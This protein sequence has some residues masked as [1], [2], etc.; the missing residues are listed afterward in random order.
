MKS[1]I[2]KYF[3]A[4]FLTATFTQFVLA[5]N[6]TQTL[7]KDS[8]YQ[9]Q[10][11]TETTETGITNQDIHTTQKKEFYIDT[12]GEAKTINY[13]VKTAVPQ[14]YGIQIKDSAKYAKKTLAPT[15]V[16]AGSFIGNMSGAQAITRINNDFINNT[17]NVKVGISGGGLIGTVNN[18]EG[19][20]RVENIT[21]D[22]I[23]NIVNAQ[24]LSGSGLIGNYGYGYSNSSD[25]IINNNTQTDVIK[26]NFIGNKIT[27]STY[28]NGSGLIGNFAHASKN[29]NVTTKIG[30]I[31]GNFYNNEITYTPTNSN[32]YNMFGG[33][34][35]GNY[36]FTYQGNAVANANIG[37]ISG[38]FVNNK[39]TSNTSIYGGGLIGNYTNTNSSGGTANASIDNIKGN[40]IK[41]TVKADK[42]IF[43]GIIG[44]YG[45]TSKNRVAL[46]KEINANFYNNH[47]E[48]TNATNT[49]SRIQGGVI[50]NIGIS[51]T[52]NKITG[53][54]I[55]N[56]AIVNSTNNTSYAYG[57]AIYNSGNITEGI[58]NS[59]FIG[60]YVKGPDAKG[61]AIYS[62]KDITIMANKYNSIFSGNYTQNATEKEDNAI[63]IAGNSATLTLETK[64][65]GTIIMK[66]SINGVEGYNVHIKSDG[67]GTF[68]MYNDIKNANV[69]F[70]NTKIS[71]VNHQIHDYTFNS[72]MLS[73]TTKLYVDVD[74][75]SK[76]MDRVIA[77]TYGGNGKLNIAGMNL[78]SD[79]KDTSETIKF[80]DS[81]LANNVTSSVSTAYS[82]IYKYTVSYVIEEDG[83][84]YFKFERGAGKPSTS[85]PGSTTIV[86]IP[87]TISKIKTEFYTNNKGK[88]TFINYDVKSAD[89]AYYTEKVNN[90]E[91]TEGYSDKTLQPTSVYGYG[92]TGNKLYSS[93]ADTN[94]TNV[95]GN[96]VG[97]KVTTKSNV[98]GSGLIGNYVYNPEKETK[99]AVIQKISGNFVS[100][101][102]T[103]NNVYGA[104]LVGNYSSISTDC[105]AGTEIKDIKGNFIGNTIT[106]K[107]NLYGGG[108][109]GNYGKT[110]TY[111]YNDGRVYNSPSASLKIGSI[112]GDF[113][114]NKIYHST[115]SSASYYALRG[116]GLIGNAAIN[117]SD[118]NY[119]TN[120]YVKEEHSISSEIGSIS[121]TFSNNLLKSNLDIVGGGIIG[122]Y[123]SG[124]QNAEIA[125]TTTATIGKIE[126]TF[127][128][129]TVTTKQH[130]NAGIIG[131][132]TVGA[133]TVSTKIDEINA[134]FYNNHAES[135]NTT[136]AN[137]RAQG[138]AIS[139]YV[140]LNG[141][142]E[143]GQAVIGKISG[144]FVENGVI[145]TSTKDG[146]TAKGG[147]IFN[148]GE[149]TEGIINSSFIGN[150][151]KSGAA[152]GAMGGAIYSDKDIRILSDKNTSI[153]ANNYTESA[154]VKEDNAIYIN[155]ATLTIET[156]NKGSIVM[157]DSI[158]GSD[159]NVNITGDGTGTFYMYNDIKNANV[160]FGNTNISTMDNEV[161]D[162][163]FNSLTLGG[164]T[165][166]YVD[167]DLANKAMDRIT[168]D[169]YGTHSG[170]IN[171]AGLNLISDSSESK[172]KILF[173][174]NGLSN[175]VSVRRT[176]YS[177]M[178]KY[179]VRYEIDKET[180]DGYINFIRAGVASSS[181]GGNSYTMYNPSVLALPAAAMTGLYTA[182]LQVFNY[183]FRHSEITMNNPLQ[184]RK[185]E[186]ME[187]KYALANDGAGIFSPLVTKS[188]SAGVWI[189][190]YATFENVPLKHGPKVS[191]ISYGTLVGYD[192]PVKELKYGW[193][194]VLTYYLGYNGASQSFSGI[195]SYQNG[196][197]LGSTITLYKNNFFNATTVSAGA[198]VGEN[199]TMY[200]SETF[201][202][203]IAGIANKMGYNAEFFDGKFIIQPSMLVGY[204]FINAFDYTNAGG[205]R[206][207]SDPMSIIQLAP[208]LKFIGNTKNGWQP[209]IAVGMVW[210]IMAHSQVFANNVELPNMYIKPYIQYGV[211]VQ[212]TIKSR[213]TAFGQAMI[214]NGG[215]NGVSLT[216]GIRWML[217]K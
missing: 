28:F 112:S 24:S 101:S 36:S 74:L 169:T 203:I 156:K 89:T 5:E 216:T 208:T 88:A 157:K 42:D 176:A 4:L 85:N 21:G 93:T 163:T 59:N 54:F 154:G 111:N 195:D 174:D 134:S 34:L 129:N 148:N 12:D 30:E 60:N 87:G 2:G 25:T 217:G 37:I 20:I 33:G 130:L 142:E 205:V 128:N 160:T 73:G 110:N 204:T 196:G 182:Q 80:I 173:T 92:I 50:S 197:L 68:Y 77:S 78:L 75:A 15:R 198:N 29:A 106:A 132:T 40:F 213:L 180:Q 11:T 76:T 164:A 186:K 153:F 126:G 177:P 19:T 14:Q 90:T 44:N 55:E 64:N 70:D 47:I 98:I 143:S 215:R 107:N 63:Y 133:K 83:N 151:A 178:Y 181:S 115:S 95:D 82:P 51:S 141:A 158:N 61:G 10:Q 214:F 202:A 97:N 38:N 91:K 17:V 67:T 191:S 117:A 138:G 194:R 140:Q 113:H 96:F 1:T 94:T 170:K 183:A 206:I 167:V 39:I 200:G 122:N 172:T 201:T 48:S 212:K 53:D 139:N 124:N 13:E 114:N 189:R 3:I 123:A 66:D 71:M 207:D 179:G 135:T 166:L 22:Y 6:L 147:A 31:T 168:A 41:N 62:S 72:L 136:L 121:G 162:Y 131:N 65:K 120:E 79:S 188:E 149:I 43:G 190:P 211:G 161:R 32:Y 23:N 16:D 192:E 58:V 81:A 108:L 109:I 8:D 144:T 104:G 118:K 146:S 49:N 56:G 209:Y 137:A 26:G 9:L 125:N 193:D 103:G 185:L 45:A 199:S 150:Y 86:E 100:N 27:I 152:N 210:N 155:N 145:T 116:G 52:I 127:I 46:I 187:G 84:G 102:V 159:Y 7:G 18:A 35:I 119:D 184:A 171:I 105:K 175:N 57:G 99:T 69:T 165:K